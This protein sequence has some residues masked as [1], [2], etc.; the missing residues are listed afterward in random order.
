MFANDARVVFRLLCLLL[1]VPRVVLQNFLPQVALVDVHVN[2][3]RADVF[4]PEHRL[5]V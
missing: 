5:E 1:D 4:V 2:L 3:C